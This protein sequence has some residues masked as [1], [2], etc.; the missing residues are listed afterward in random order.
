MT[1]YLGEAVA[2]TGGLEEV[3][4]RQL[5]VLPH[6]YPMPERVAQVGRRAGVGVVGD[7]GRGVPVEVE[8]GLRPL[9]LQGQR[10]PLAR[11]V[12]LGQLHK[13]AA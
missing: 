3:P 5:V 8:L 13:D 7:L 9:A 12:G 1:T 4:P 11:G 6:A 2:K 10:G